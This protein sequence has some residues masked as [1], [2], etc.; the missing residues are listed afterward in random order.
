MELNDLKKTW[1]K[2][3]VEKELDERNDSYKAK[4][5]QRLI[6]YI[7]DYLFERGSTKQ[8]QVLYLNQL[9]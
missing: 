2:L 8:N 7:M 4:A 9:V 6:D 3:S 5:A 1:N